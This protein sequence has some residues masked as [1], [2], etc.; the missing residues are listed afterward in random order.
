[1]IIKLNTFL[2]RLA[3][4]K[5]ETSQKTLV[6]LTKEQWVKADRIVIIA[7]FIL[8]IVSAILF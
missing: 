7:M 1:M 6:P 5:E 8:T 3:R 4:H 2:F